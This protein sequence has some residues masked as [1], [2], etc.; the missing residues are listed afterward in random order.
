MISTGPFLA[1]AFLAQIT[2]TP[3]DR[4]VSADSARTL[5]A[6]PEFNRLFEEQLIDAESARFRDVNLHDGGLRLCGLVN[7]R[8]RFGGYVGWRK[9]S[10]FHFAPYTLLEIE[11]PSKPYIVVDCRERTSDVDYSSVFSGTVHKD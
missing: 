7:A 8:N 4:S 9:F 6:V 3:A 1:A 11:D 10:A 2:A 5:A